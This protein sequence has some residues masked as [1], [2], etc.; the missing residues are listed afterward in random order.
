MTSPKQEFF[1]WENDD[2]MSRLSIVLAEIG[3]IKNNIMIDTI[4]LEMVNIQ[5]SNNLD[6]SDLFRETQS[7]KELYYTFSPER[8]LVKKVGY[9]PFVRI[10]FDKE[11][12]KTKL[13]FIASLCKLVHGTNYY[14]IDEN[15]YIICMERIEECCSLLGVTVNKKQIET[16]II[17]KVAFAHNFI[18]ADDF[19]YPSEY[20]PLLTQ[21]DAGVRY[22]EVQNCKFIEDTYGYVWK[23][24]N[25]NTSLGFYDKRAELINNA[26]TPEGKEIV[27]L[28]K[29]G[30]L[31]SN[32]LRFEVTY[33]N[34]ESVNQH[35]YTYLK[36]EINQNRHLKDIFNNKLVQTILMKEFNKL[37]NIIDIKAISL[38]LFPIEQIEHVCKNA[39]LSQLQS[40]A[41]VG[42]MY[43]TTMMGAKGYKKMI[44]RYRSRQ[45]RS[46]TEKQ[47]EKLLQKYPL[48]SCYLEDIFK[49]CHKKLE[50]FHLNKPKQ[51]V[52]DTNI[53]NLTHFQLP[54]GY[55]RT[56]Y[57]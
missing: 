29:Q 50:T 55:T 2:D 54:Y 1:Y 3:T 45:S 15:D 9:L 12:K 31:P 23:Q 14:A 17:K 34:K 6:R 49:I 18:L 56:N 19:P 8:V 5:L 24:Y 32:I 10:T 57:C 51:P 53:S 47:Y 25:Q 48:P 21:L 28:C 22:K 43:K 20:L 46:Q 37:L 4:A 16:G 40:D 36:G 26:I 39:G 41:I 13:L 30:L 38:P 7:K 27:A 11:T 42:R 44:A 35:L 52:L 33:Q